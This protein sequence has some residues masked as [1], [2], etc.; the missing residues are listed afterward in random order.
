MRIANMSFLLKI[1]VRTL[2]KV[3]RTCIHCNMWNIE[4]L[5][6]KIVYYLYLYMKVYT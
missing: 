2:L 5:K 1:I 4:E 3:R 6:N